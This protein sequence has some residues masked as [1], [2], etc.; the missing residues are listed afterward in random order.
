MH[1]IF[2]LLLLLLLILMRTCEWA[3]ISY[4]LTICKTGKQCYPRYTNV[5]SLVHKFIARKLWMKVPIRS[6]KLPITK[7]HAYDSL[8]LLF[9]WFF[10]LSSMFS[11]VSSFWLQHVQS[12]GSVSCLDMCVPIIA[13][14]SKFFR[15]LQYQQAETKTKTE[16]EAEKVENQNWITNVHSSNTQYEHKFWF[17]N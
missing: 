9:V 3:S 8:K 11:V 17:E 7:S 2:H 1:Y 4:Y 5:I 15:N 10:F 16:T 6:E 14:C 12:V 13:S